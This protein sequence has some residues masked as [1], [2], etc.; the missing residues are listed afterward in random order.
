MGKEVII[1]PYSTTDFNSVIELLRLNTPKYFAAEEESDLIN[2]LNNE[3]D[4]YFVAEHNSSVIGC[5]G[6]NLVD[7]GKT[8]R[9]SSDIIHPGYQGKGV[10]IKIIKHRLDYISKL[11]PIEKIVVRTTQLVYPFYE[12]FGFKLKGFV[13]DYWAQGFDMHIMERQ[14]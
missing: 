8:A 1:R 3:I 13:K 11:D 5:G 6:I 14:P 7:D 9:I 2:Y 12:K 4:F 10:G